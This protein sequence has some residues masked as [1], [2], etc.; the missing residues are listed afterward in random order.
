MRFV[1]SSIM[2]PTSSRLRTVGS[3]RGVLGKGRSSKWMSRRLS[4]FL[5]K[6]RKADI[7]YLHRDWR[8]LSFLQQVPLEALNVRRSQTVWWL[9]E[10]IRELFDRENIATDCGF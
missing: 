10:I 4:I 2:R 5:K 7:S 8:E 6:N 3:F 1:V 9:T